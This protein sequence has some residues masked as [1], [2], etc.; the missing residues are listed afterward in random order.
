MAEPSTNPE[1]SEAERAAA[2]RK[3]LLPIFII[4]FIDVLGLTLI[5]PILPAYAQAYG[6]SDL[7]VGLLLSSFAVCQFF[8]SPVLGRLSD[9]LG[10]KPVL[11]A[12]QVGMIGSYLVLGFAR[13]LWMVFLGRIIAG[14]TAG[15][16]SIAQAYISDVTKPE[17]RTRTYGLIGVAFGTGFMFGPPIAGVL[18]SRIH[19]SAPFFAAAAVSTLSATVTAL[20]LPHRKPAPQANAVRRSRIGQ[21]TELFA[22]PEPRRRLVEFFVFQLAFSMLMGGGFTLFL[23]HLFAFNTEQIGYMFLYSGVI[24]AII[25][26]GLVGRLAKRLGEE[27]LAV[28]GFATAALG[29]VFLGLSAGRLWL[30]LLMTGIGQFGLGVIRPA[31]TT[32]LTKAVGPSEQGKALGVSTSLTSIAQIICPI[33]AASLIHAGYLTG[34]GVTVA[35]FAALGALL[36]LQRSPTVAVTATPEGKA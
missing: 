22:R 6:A 29:H 28:L 14:I 23:Q 26:G 5:I 11:I 13:T 1:Q 31:L 27:K 4:V 35:A 7:T 20:L 33:I 18:S 17:E 15:N 32:L 19:P 21:I 16:L 36:V 3:A 8:A 34:Y 12:S 9:S 10:R 30:L 24:G 2:T 25:Q